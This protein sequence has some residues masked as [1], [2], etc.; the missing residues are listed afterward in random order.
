VECFFVSLATGGEGWH[1]FHHTFP[2]D[3][4]ASEYGQNRDVS[5]ILIELVQ[6][7]GWAYDLRKTPQ[8]LVNNWAKNFGDG[9][10]PLAWKEEDPLTK[11][12]TPLSTSKNLDILKMKPLR[13]T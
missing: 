6:R 7:L 5:T 11:R 3:Y 1:N 8:H 2:S 12:A 10:H 4:S 9:S 13:E